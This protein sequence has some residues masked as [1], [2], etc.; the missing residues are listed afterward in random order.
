MELQGPVCDLAID[1]EYFD[2]ELALGKTFEH[3]KQPDTDT[4]FGYVVDGSVEVQGKTIAQRTMRSLWRKAILSK[5]TSKNGKPL[6]LW[7]RRTVE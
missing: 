4:V 7:V 1:I 2:V 3:S 5:M 6:S